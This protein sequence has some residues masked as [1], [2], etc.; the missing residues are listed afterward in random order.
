MRHMNH[1]QPMFP[2]FRH[3]FLVAVLAAFVAAQ[4]QA[5]RAQEASAPPSTPMNGEAHFTILIFEAP[6]DLARRTTPA[7][8]EAYWRA[9]DDFAAVLATR[10]ALRGGSALSETVAETVRGTG[11]ADR[12]VQGARLGGYFIVA[13]PSLAEARALA[14]EAPAF[15]V[16][17]EVRP[18]RPNPRMAAR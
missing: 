12:G 8:A 3:G 10:G 11:S 9:Y 15:A 7:E 4:P 14:R 18:H 5:A 1:R 17:V 16:A 2:F 6:R 13:A